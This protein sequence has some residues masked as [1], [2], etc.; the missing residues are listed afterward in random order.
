MVSLHIQAKHGMFCLK[1]VFVAQSGVVMSTINSKKIIAK[2]LRNN[3]VYKTDPPVYSI[4]E[5]ESYIDNKVL[6]KL[7]FKKCDLNLEA[8]NLSSKNN[9]IFCLFDNGK[10]TDIG[11]RWLEI[12]NGIS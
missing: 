8:K 2:L 3:G 6:Y 5:Y 11:K 7:F 4:L 10:L 1:R 9:D 12:Y